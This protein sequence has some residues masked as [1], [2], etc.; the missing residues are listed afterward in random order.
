MPLLSTLLVEM[1]LSPGANNLLC[2]NIR[3]AILPLPMSAEEKKRIRNILSIWFW[4]TT[5]AFVINK[6]QG[7]LPDR[8]VVEL[9]P[10]EPK[11]VHV[12]DSTVSII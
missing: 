2:E 1:D 4:Y 7:L 10:N 3:Q 5:Q 6:Y 11:T 9:V 12:Y 8:A